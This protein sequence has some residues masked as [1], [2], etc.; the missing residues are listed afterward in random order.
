MGSGG[1][2]EVAEGRYIWL[3]T[4]LSLRLAKYQDASKE[5]EDLCEFTFFAQ[6]VESE[7]WKIRG[8]GQCPAHCQRFRPR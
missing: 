4:C 8:L 2:P 1:N 5:K 6:G 3:P 7:K